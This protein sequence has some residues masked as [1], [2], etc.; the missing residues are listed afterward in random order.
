MAAQCNRFPPPEVPFGSVRGHGRDLCGAE[1]HHLPTRRAGCRSAIAISAMLRAPAAGRAQPDR[2]PPSRSRGPAPA[3]AGTHAGATLTFDP[4]GLSADLL[5]TVT[6]EGYTAPTPVQAAAIPLV[7]EGRD[8]LAAAQTGTGKTAAFTLPILD[9]LR[10]AREHVASRRPA[11]RSAPSSSSP[12][13]SSRCRST[14]ASGPTAGPSRSARPSSTAASRWI[15]QIKALRGGIEILVATPGR[16]LDLV[17]QKVANLGQVEIL[18]LDEADRMLDMGFLPDIQR[19]IELLP[20]QRQNLMF[21]ATFSDDIRRL[22]RTIL[23]DPETVEVA[24]RNT[25]RRDDP[26]ARLPGRPR[27]QGGA[28]RPPR[29]AQDDLHQVLVFTRTKLAASRLASRL[30]PRRA[31]R[32]RDPLATARSRSGRARSRASSR[33]RSACSSRPTSRPAASTSRTCRSSSTSSCR[34]TRRTTSTGSAGPAGPARRARRSASSASTRSTC[35]GAS[36]GCSS[37]PSRGRSRRASSPTGTPS[38]GR[39]GCG[40]G[41]ARVGA[42][43]HAHRKPVRRRAGA[44]SG[45]GRADGG[46]R[47]PKPGSGRRR[48]G[49]R[50]GA[51]ARRSRRPPCSIDRRA[52]EEEARASGRPRPARR[53][54]G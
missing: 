12:P 2:R 26:A 37:R 13:A 8:V 16:L 41:H 35:C 45:G 4:L 10:A 29:S 52:R 36:S 1:A 22:S 50:S 24:P 43:H 32:R 44:A 17:G 15:P 11:T 51:A 3:T 31:R 18:V 6:E 40:P 33:A 5:Q 47:R 42:E 19:I 27:P 23:R 38:R 53:C 28:A 34:G 46:R 25:D 14:R 39:S 21:S 7:L 48:C 20:K 54:S 30:G 49:A 9:R